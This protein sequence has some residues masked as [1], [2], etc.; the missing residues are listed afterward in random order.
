M[1][2]LAPLVLLLLAAGPARAQDMG[3]S[4]AAGSFYTAWLSPPR[5]SGIPAPAARA[6]IE[7]L[8]SARLAQLMAA[9][10]AAD[11][12]FRTANRF[13]PPLLEGDLFSSLAEG[14]AS[15]QVGTCTGTAT[16]QRCRIRFHRPPELKSAGSVRPADW[17]DDLLLVN[18]GGGWKVDDVDYRGGFPYG[19]TGLLSQALTMVIQAAR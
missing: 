8:L 12:R 5:A 14:P 9:A 16:A 11:A 1:I 13:A 19:N 17:G 10:A 6:R 4:R 15:F 3:A 7:P 2:R 18:E